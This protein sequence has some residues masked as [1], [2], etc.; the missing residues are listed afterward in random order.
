MLMYMILIIDYKQRILAEKLKI[1]K[2]ADLSQFQISNWE[3]NKSFVEC[4]F[5]K[6]YLNKFISK[7][8]LAAVTSL[9]AGGANGK[10]KTKD[11]YMKFT[12][13]LPNNELFAKQSTPYVYPLF[14]A[15]KLSML[16]L[17]NVSPD[18]VHIKIPSR[19]IVGMSSCQLSRAQIW[20][21]HLLTPLSIFY[22]NYF[23]AHLDNIKIKAVNDNW[24]WDDMVLFTI[25]LKALY[26][27]V[28]FQYLCLELKHCFNKCTCWNND[29]KESI[30]EIIIYTLKHQQIYWENKYYVLDQG[31]PTGGKH[32]V[33][34]ANIFLTFVLLYSLENDAK[35][36]QHFGE[37][38]TFW[39]IFIDDG[40]GIMRG[41]INYFLE[42]YNK[43]Q[44]V[45]HK[46]G[47]ELTCDTDSH[48]IEGD[49]IVEKQVKGIQFLDMVILRLMKLSTAK[50][51]GKKLL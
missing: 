3:E 29:V 39:K 15:H 34:I 20:L 47:L 33:P 21:E 23:L 32:S 16:E 42:F 19:L 41:S 46:Y 8:E 30:I 14:K 43:L 40:F 51:I 27:S 18:D 10:L 2:I 12:R 44:G 11:N 35:F 6:L 13:T 36:E 50:N 31:I 26:P 28:K 1:S 37:L 24:N 4:S 9:L 25:D 38:I 49:N 17:L 7:E 5:K 48:K 22:G 45:F